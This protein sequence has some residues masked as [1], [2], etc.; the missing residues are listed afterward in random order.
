MSID[1]FTSPQARID[2]VRQ[3]AGGFG[4]DLV[5]E[6]SGH[7]AAGPEGVEM[8][9]DGGTYVEMG[10]F[11]DA[12]SINTNWHRICTKDIT[13][14]GS[15]AFTANDIPLGIEMMHRAADRYPWQLLQTT[16]PLSEKGI[17]EATKSAIA[18][19]C[20]KATIAP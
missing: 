4:T 12:G 11:T 16:F 7:P 8:L 3:I 18:M 5:I 1:Q 17:V 10:Q 20:L 2:A 13:I 6:C 19:R 15:W 14:L 9:R